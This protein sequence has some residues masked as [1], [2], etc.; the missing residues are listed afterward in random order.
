VSHADHDH[1]G[2]AAAV[3]DSVSVGEIWVPY[4]AAFD[5]AFGPLRALAR[6]NAI[7]V[8]E[9]GAGSPAVALGDLI[10]EPLWPAPDMERRSR[11]DRSLVFRIRVSGHSVLL[12]GDLEAGAEAELVATGVNLRS[13]V[14]ALAHH[15]S[16]TSSSARFLEAVGASVAIASAPC[17]GRFGMPHAEVLVRA[18]HASLPVW[19][20]G[21]DGAIMVGLGKPL[22]VW[23]YADQPPP[24]SCRHD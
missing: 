18:R 10:V 21:R 9:R 16:R 14:I 23:G 8:V 13:D 2:G 17:G 7:P 5:P 19:W 3:L 20:T 12:P 6:S 1:A 24:D 4:G 11:N 15:G 22:T